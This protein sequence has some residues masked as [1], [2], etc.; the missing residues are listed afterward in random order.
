MKNIIC[1]NNNFIRVD[2]I[3]S[4]SGVKQV[5][6]NVFHFKVGL[7]S[8][9]LFTFSYQTKEEASN[10]FE[11]VYDKW[12]EKHEKPYMVNSLLNDVI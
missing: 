2:R 1:I 6:M 7:E 10:K 5:E 4:L 11:Y 8:G 9:E 3:E 12:I